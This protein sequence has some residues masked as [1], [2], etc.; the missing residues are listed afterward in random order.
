LEYLFNKIFPENIVKL[1]FNGS[2]IISSINFKSNNFKKL[3]K[4]EQ[5]NLYINTT[6]IAF[7][8]YDYIIEINNIF[9]NDN[10]DKIYNAF[11]ENELNQKNIYPE[12]W[13]KIIHYI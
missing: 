4:E 12:N 9:V 10:G 6:Q 8:N 7:I 3:S 1:I 5:I 2:D 11:D 13:R